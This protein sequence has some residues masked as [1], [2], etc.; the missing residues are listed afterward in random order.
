MRKSLK[1]I[2]LQITEPEYREM[3]ELSYST[4]AKYERGGFNSIKTLQDKVESPSLLYGG[5]VDTYL[6]DGVDAFNEKYFVAIFPELKDSEIAVIKSIFAKTNGLIIWSKVTNDT[7]LEA[8]DECNYQPNWRPE[9]RLKNIKEKGEEYYNLLVLSKDKVLISQEMY[10]DVLAAVDVLKSSEATR[11]F[12]AENN[13]FENVERLYQLKFNTV[14]NGIGYRC[15]FDELIVNYDDKTIQP[16]DLKTSY[17]NEYDFYKSFVEWSYQIQNRLYV[18][19]LQENIK[20]DPF[21]KD[22]KI[23]PYKDIVVCKTSLNPLVWD[24][25]FTFAVGTLKFGKNDQIEMRDPEVIGKE[26]QY[27]LDNN[28]I[29]PQ[30]IDVCGSND[31]RKWLNTL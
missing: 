1:D 25:D 18:R 17:K 21:F 12:F 2:S 3:P 16:I 15:M 19:I 5:C 8:I 13:P 10:E 30:G 26:L 14:L 20:K 23:L 11:W 31:L 29:V 22:F 28:S 4:L 7:I 6:T 24:C 27:Y 9:T